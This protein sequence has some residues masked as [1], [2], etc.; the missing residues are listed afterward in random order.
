MRCHSSPNSKKCGQCL[1]TMDNPSLYR[2]LSAYHLMKIVT[3]AF[4]NDNSD[5]W[6][7]VLN[8]SMVGCNGSIYPSYLRV[9][10]TESLLSTKAS[11]KTI[12][13]NWYALNKSLDSSTNDFNIQ[14]C[15]IIDIMDLI[16]DYDVLSHLIKSLY[17]KTCK[18]IN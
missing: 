3:V 14:I 6:Q 12:F 13:N 7:L 2:D 9:L 16:H 11:I 18:Y 4:V 8:K 5:R 15:S 10:E 17:T 1:L